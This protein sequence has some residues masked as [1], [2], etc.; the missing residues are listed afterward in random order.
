MTRQAPSLSFEFFP[1]ATDAGAQKL[2]ETHR[3][4]QALQ[5]E[6]FSVTFGAGGTTQARTTEIVTA[7]T[8]AGSQ[9]APHLTCVGATR[10]S[11]RSLLDSYRDQ[12]IRRLVALRGD[13]PSGMVGLGDFRHA[14]DLIRFIR[15]AY[16]DWF[17]LEVAAYPEM[18]PQ[19]ESPDAD[20]ARFA[21]KAAAGAHS[22]I[23]Q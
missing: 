21:E 13:L 12:G 4:L 3:A 20:L 18:H 10:E 7:L 15:D 19:A 14:I 8:Q 9:V 11:I 22:A 16:G 5:P 23:T 6:Y 17:S 2:L 1:P